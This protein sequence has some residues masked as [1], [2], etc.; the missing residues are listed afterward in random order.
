MS[1]HFNWICSNFTV[2]AK[3]EKSNSILFEAY[4]E[5]ICEINGQAFDI[6]NKEDFWKAVEMFKGE[7]FAE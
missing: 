1:K 4:S 5:I 2:L 6:D 7:D 3:D